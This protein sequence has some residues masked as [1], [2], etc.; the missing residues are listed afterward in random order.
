[1]VFLTNGVALATVSLSGGI[2][3]VSTVKVEGRVLRLTVTNIKMAQADVM[4]ELLA[5]SWR[6]ERLD[7][8]KPS[9][10]EIFVRLVGEEG[11][12]Q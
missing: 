4:K 12:A 6:F 8:V 7:V 3:S 9:L 11:R 2:A 5:E 1:M 10:E